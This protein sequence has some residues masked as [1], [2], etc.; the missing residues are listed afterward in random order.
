MNIH[1]FALR[2]DRKHELSAKR[3]C[4]STCIYEAAPCTEEKEDKQLNI[5]KQNHNHFNPE[6][7]EKSTKNSIRGKKLC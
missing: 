5:Y 6:T 4:C 1:S 3:Q 2:I 7:E